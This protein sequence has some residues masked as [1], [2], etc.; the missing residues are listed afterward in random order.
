MFTP[1]RRVQTRPLHSVVI[2]VAELSQPAFHPPLTVLRILH[3]RLPFW[4][5]DLQLPEDFAGEKPPISV[6]DVLV[7]V[8]RACHT[9]ISQ[10]DWDSLNTADEVA[11][12]KAFALRCRTEAM[13]SSVSQM[14]RKDREVAERNQGVKRVDFLMEKTVLKGFMRAP[15]DPEGCVRMVT[16]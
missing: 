7:A 6:G 9:R 13:N 11:V 3:P 14:H 5:I 2:T 4:P 12:T 8:H 15:D 16:A 10:V 1:L